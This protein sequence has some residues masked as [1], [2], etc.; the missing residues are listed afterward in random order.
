MAAAF[1]LIA[2]A[3]CG[4]GIGE[5]ASPPSPT[6]PATAASP[7]SA[8]SPSPGSEP[9]T[10]YVEA[11]EDLRDLAT[12]FVTLALGYQAETEEPLT[13]LGRLEGLATTAELMRL[14]R[15][16][17]ARLRWWVLRQRGE[18]ATVHVTGVSQQA[19]PTGAVTLHVEGIRVTSSGLGSVRDFVDVT[20]V[21]VG[22]SEG[23]RVD[24]AE[25]GGL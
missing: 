6:E 3:G 4:T 11:A 15:S 17:R 16:E 25:G 22:T 9:A 8:I 19:D 7:D 10:P 14:R 24:R 2:C 23:W 5:L 18:T 1:G 21:V 13:F 12:R 20:L